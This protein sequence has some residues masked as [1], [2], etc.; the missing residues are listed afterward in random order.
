[1]SLQNDA[2]LFIN[3][4]KGKMKV[5]IFK[6][7]DQLVVTVGKQVTSN[8]HERKSNYIKRTINDDDHEVILQSIEMV[9]ENIHD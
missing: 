9:K 7:R 8:E 1:M 3:L 4:K 5:I 2:S 6:N